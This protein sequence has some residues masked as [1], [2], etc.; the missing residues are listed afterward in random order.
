MFRTI[1]I[2]WLSFALCSLLFAFLGLSF[3]KEFLLP[4]IVF[5][6]S[7]LLLFFRFIIKVD[8]KY[9]EYSVGIGI[10]IGRYA[11]SEVADC[12]SLDFLPTNK[13]FNN[14]YIKASIHSGSKLIEITMKNGQSHILATSAPHALTRF[15]SEMSRKS[16]TVS[17]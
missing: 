9:I 1:K 10:V 11:L 7:L 5:T 3:G 4:I 17:A 12:Q 13:W 15:I 14:R 6:A 16:S 8:E 2:C